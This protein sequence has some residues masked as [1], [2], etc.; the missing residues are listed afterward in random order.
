M[1]ESKGLPRQVGVG[2]TLVE[3]VHDVHQQRE[4]L[5][6]HHPELSLA[7]YGLTHHTGNHKA[8]QSNP[9][10]SLGNFVIVQSLAPPLF[11]EIAILGFWVV[12][13]RALFL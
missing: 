2:R 7:A 6:V 13:Q 1:V 10:K 3:D 9:G 12:F 5:E 8:F 4:V 11:L